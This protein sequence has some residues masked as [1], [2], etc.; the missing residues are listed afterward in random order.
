MTFGN[1]ICQLLIG[2]FLISSMSNDL[3]AQELTPSDLLDQISTQKSE[4]E[5][6][7]FIRSLAEKGEIPYTTGDSCVFLYLGYA[8]S[9]Q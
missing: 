3:Y 8:E 2:C 5:A 1:R 7:D 9:V 4:Q 6:L